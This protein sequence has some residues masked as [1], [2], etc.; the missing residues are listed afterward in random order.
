[1]KFFFLILLF[2]IKLLDFEL[3][4]FIFFIQSYRSYIL[5][6]VLIKLS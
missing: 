6:Y 5:N 1:M 3:C 2:D 4:E